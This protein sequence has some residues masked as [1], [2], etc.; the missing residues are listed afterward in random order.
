M[1]FLYFTLFLTVFL[2]SPSYLK[3]QSAIGISIFPGK[4]IFVYPKYTV[5]L[6]S[7]LTNSGSFG[8]DKDATIVFSGQR[9]INQAGSILPDESITGSTGI[10][11]VF[12]FSGQG[13]L[14][15]YIESGNNLQLGSE[16]PNISIDNSQNVIL[17][18]SDL[19]IR[20][21]LNFE[22]GRLILN[23]RN[24]NIGA[25]GSITGYN[26]DRFIVT[27]TSTRGGAL[28]RS[29]TGQ[30]QMDIVF[31]IGSSINSYTP[32]SINYT[33]LSQDLKLRVFENVYDKALSGLIDNVF[34]VSKTWHLALVRT[35]NTAQL[36]IN[37]QHNRI[38]EGSA[39]TGSRSQSFIS[40][41]L[42]NTEQWDTAPASVVSP[43]VITT[44]NPIPNS[45]VSSRTNLS[46]LS[47]NE[48][49][50]KAVRKSDGFARLR[51]PE[52][53][54]P[55]DDGLNDRFVMQNM[56]LTDNFS[57]EI[58]NKEQRIV[59]KDLNYRNTFEGI[60]NQNEFVNS[61]LPNGTYY[62]LLN[63][64][65]ERSFRGFLVIKR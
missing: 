1:K 40:R 53:I 16:F 43:G 56:T 17:E 37:L 44:T 4:S 5:A 12:K 3:C 22:S 61:T 58:Y 9:W 35:D 34:S 38:K 65:E 21:N 36:S 26:E 19:A 6:I 11:G 33:G 63:V 48:Y 13:S 31:P 45:F 57:L 32:A 24:V 29:V 49:F 47:S 15:Q 27:G 8:S 64:N 39:Y 46:G 23:T 18:G 30:Q 60:G 51:I 54:S 52:G 55:N 28:I 50:S 59:Y 14:P 41:F 2:L 10:G 20:N 7:D 25:K 62:Y 42:A